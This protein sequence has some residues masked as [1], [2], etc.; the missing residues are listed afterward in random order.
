MK[1]IIWIGDSLHRLRSFPA[2]ARSDAGY[3]L[4]LV[5]T[6]D[7]PADFRPMPQ[8]GPGTMEIRVHTGTEYRV[9]YVARFA[10]AV[11]VLHS[12]AKKTRTTRQSDLDLAR[13]RYRI[14]L[15]NRK[16]EDHQD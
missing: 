10:E 14:M 8:V 16:H 9:L 1:P 15:E 4:Q 13:Q 11:Y 7:P 2:D 3:Q 12:F 5:Q 6:G